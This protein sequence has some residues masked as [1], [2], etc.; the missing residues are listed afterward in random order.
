MPGPA[1]GREMPGDTGTR[2]APAKLGRKNR[3][4]EVILQNHLMLNQSTGL[5]A[6]VGTHSRP[7]PMCVRKGA[8]LEKE[9]NDGTPKTIYACLRFKRKTKIK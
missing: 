4:F 8:P 1:P 3:V 6:A 7:P 2:P 9:K 5:R